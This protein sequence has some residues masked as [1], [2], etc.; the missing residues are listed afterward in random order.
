[1]RGFMAGTLRCS[2]DHGRLVGHAPTEQLLRMLQH[3]RSIFRQAGEVP[4]LVWILGEIEEQRRERSEV[5]VLVA[6]SAKHGQ[7]TLLR[8]EPGKAARVV[9]KVELE[10][11]LFTPVPWLAPAKER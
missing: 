3:E 11:R 1:M 5:N 9:S 7:V 4:K 8:I 2:F 6:F 10:M